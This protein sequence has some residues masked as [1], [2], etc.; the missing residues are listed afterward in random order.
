MYINSK[1]VKE[2]NDGHSETK[3]H[4]IISIPH[5]TT[6][7]TINGN[8]INFANSHLNGEASLKGKLWPDR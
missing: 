4:S 5:R 1:T 7:L 6:N 2:L 8:T 3:V